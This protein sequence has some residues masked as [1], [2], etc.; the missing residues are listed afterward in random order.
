MPAFLILSTVATMGFLCALAGFLV[1]TASVAFVVK[2]KAVLGETSSSN[3][4]EWGKIKANLTSAVSLF[5]LGALMIA[6]PFWRFAQDAARQPATAI[7][8]GK[9]VG[10]GSKEVRMLL[11]VKP[12][13]D[14]NYAGDIVWQFPLVAKKM[15]YAVFYID[16]DTVLRQ[17]PFSV[18]DAPL[19]SAPQEYS[20]P[21]FEVQ[22][23]GIAQQISPKLEVSD[24]EL[25]K[26]GID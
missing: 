24:A 14:Q 20:L 25:K 10:T 6:L 8:K 17:Q 21:A 2:G 1:I 3:T 11:V 4:V 22:T 12:D 9:I 26:L 15:S 23:N 7:L 18:K 16:G 5:V 13:Y 19:G